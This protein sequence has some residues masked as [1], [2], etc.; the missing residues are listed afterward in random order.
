MTC[1]VSVVVY[2]KKSGWADRMHNS[3]KVTVSCDQQ[4]GMDLT[5]YETD[6][7]NWRVRISHH[8]SLPE[9]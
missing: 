5:I 7:R 4:D 9:D 8:F 1:V 2:L 3:R 6:K